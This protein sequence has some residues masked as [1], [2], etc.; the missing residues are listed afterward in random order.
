MLLTEPEV[1]ERLRCSTSKV[2]RLRL[3]GKLPYIPGRPLMIVEA[4]LEAYIEA[5]RRTAE[6]KDAPKSEADQVAEAAALARRIWLT[7][8]LQGRGRTP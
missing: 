4:D 8:R 2:K 5:A 7:R 1:A 3:E 6:A